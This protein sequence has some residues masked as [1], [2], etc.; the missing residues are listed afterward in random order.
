MQRLLRAWTHAVEGVCDLVAQQRVRQHRKGSRA[1][2]CDFLEQRPR[3]VEDSVRE[4]RLSAIQILA[5]VVEQPH[6]FEAT[7][8]G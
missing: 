7:N 5:L 8:R 4:V 6:C 2:L 1:L 3:A